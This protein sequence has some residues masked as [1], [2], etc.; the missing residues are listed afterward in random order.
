[1]LFQA[2]RRV[3][4]PSSLWLLQGGQLGSC[5]LSSV[6]YLAQGLVN[7]ETLSW[8]NTSL[9]PV[10]SHALLDCNVITYI[11]LINFISVS[12]MC[13]CMCECTCACVR[14]CACVCTCACVR[15]HACACVHVRACMRACMRACVHVRACI[16][17]R[18]HY[19]CAWW[20][21]SQESIRSLTAGVT[22]GCAPSCGNWTPLHKNNKS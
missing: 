15:V 1:M 9:S 2:F 4:S 10:K 12:P 16:R 13:A 22:D 21:W 19:N 3:L 7:T 5:H 6:L 8:T 14:V 20:P 17:A 18:T 11:T